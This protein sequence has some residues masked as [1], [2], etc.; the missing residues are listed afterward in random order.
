MKRTVRFWRDEAGAA[1]V[2][3][4]LVAVLVFFPLVF[5][6]IE[7]GRIVFAKT[8]VTAAAREGVR[9]AIVHGGASGAVADST[10][11]RGESRS[12]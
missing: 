12:L 10:M 9:Y 7:L 4:A 2:E 6:L 5:G 3:F 1:M 11:V 8:T